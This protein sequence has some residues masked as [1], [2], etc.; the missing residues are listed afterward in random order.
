MFY[1]LRVFL[2]PGSA[3]LIYSRGKGR[4]GGVT[5]YWRA[6]LFTA[7]LKKSFVVHR[8]RPKIPEGDSPL[9]KSHTHVLESMHAPGGGP[10]IRPRYSNFLSAPG[11]EVRVCTQIVLYLHRCLQG[12]S[13]DLYLFFSCRFTVCSFKCYL[14]WEGVLS[15][16][17]KSVY[18]YNALWAQLPMKIVHPRPLANCAIIRMKCTARIWT[19][20]L[21]EVICVIVDRR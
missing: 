11:T 14:H 3:W 7:F 10:H 2:E 15:L 8:K 18:K 6:K 21:S 16:F 4:G 5:Q 12:K 1:P 17:S 19:L 20:T 9:D 13:I